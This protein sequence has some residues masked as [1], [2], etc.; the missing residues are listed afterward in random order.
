MW[1][2]RVL[3]ANHGIFVEREN[4]RVLFCHLTPRSENEISTRLM[5]DANYPQAEHFAARNTLQPL[6]KIE[7]LELFGQA[8]LS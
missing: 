2:V 5:P 8:E 3:H 6:S 4:S 7:M 1:L